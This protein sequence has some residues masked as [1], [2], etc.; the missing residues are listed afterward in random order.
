MAVGQAESESLLAGVRGR[1]RLLLCF[2]AVNFARGALFRYNEA[3]E[4]EVLPLE[5]DLASRK[6]TQRVLRRFG[7]RPRHRLG[8][9]F[10]VNGRVVE[11]MVAAAELGPEEVVVEVGPGIGTLTRVLATRVRQVVAVEVD[12][13]LVRVLAYTLGALANV[14]LVQADVRYLS[15]DGL[16]REA[17]ISSFKVVASLPYY[18]TSLFLRRLLTGE[19]GF[20][21]GVLMVQREVARRLLALPGSKDYG[22]LTVAV[23]YHA[24]VTPVIHV[25]PADFW[26][27]PQVAS[28]VLRLRRRHRPPVEVGEEDF[29]FRLIRAAFSQR[30]KAL[31]NA[32]AEG[33]GEPK[34]R[35]R[36]VLGEEGFG[37]KLRAEELSLADF[38]A[39]S[40]RFLGQRKG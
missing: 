19:R 37:A 11:R 17:G 14:R 6:T 40:R 34:E 38:A 16:A 8:Q 25:G 30:R 29:F 24:E 23:Q 22:V 27:R 1:K 12:A 9:N 10:L 26:P 3:V 35:V 28:T 39:L 13:Q 33:L 18:L 5:I 31:A 2:P 20:S 21:L 7:L 36:A 32:L 4:H 15:L